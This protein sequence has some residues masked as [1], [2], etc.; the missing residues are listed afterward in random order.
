MPRPSPLLRLAQAHKA[1]FESLLVAADTTVELRYPP[2]KSPASSAADKVLGTKPQETG[3]DPA[4]SRILSVI[5]SND[6]FH[7]EDVAQGSLSQLVAS[8]GHN[9]EGLPLDAVI[10]LRLSDALMD[11]A[12]PQGMTLFDSCKDV[13]YQGQSFK[14][15]STKRTGLPPLGPYI[16]W[17][18]LHRL[19]G[20]K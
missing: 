3:I 13:V 7:S 2:L 17:V 6:L 5:W 9:K 4:R 12:S 10:R 19:G 20:G 16:L 1:R 8:I 11:P 15:L 14:V 18:G